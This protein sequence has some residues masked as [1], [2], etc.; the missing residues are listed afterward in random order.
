MS[1]EV[2]KHKDVE[3]LCNQLGKLEA[4]IDAVVAKSDDSQRLK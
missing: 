3:R 1:V 4:I 2:L